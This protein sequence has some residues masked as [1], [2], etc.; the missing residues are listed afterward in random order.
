MQTILHLSH[1]TRQQF[2]EIIPQKN[3][4][5]IPATENSSQHMLRT[6]L[7]QNNTF[8]LLSSGKQNNNATWFQGF[9][10]VT[11]VV[12]EELATWTGCNSWFCWVVG[13]RFQQ[14]DNTFTTIF[15][16]VHLLDGGDRLLWDLNNWT[17]F[18]SKTPQSLAFILLRAGIL[19]QTTAQVVIQLFDWLLSL[20]VVFLGNFVSR[21]FCTCLHDSPTKM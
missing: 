17:F 4:E 2:D 5:L 18:A 12:L 13:F 10:C 20:F 6:N 8:A 14:T 7:K 3:I 11:R 9:A 19:Q 1:D 16:S 15:S 21:H